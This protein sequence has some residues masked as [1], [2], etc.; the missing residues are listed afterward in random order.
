MTCLIEVHDA[1]ELDRALALDP[2]LLGIN[3]RNL[4]TLHVDPQTVIDLLPRVPAGVLAVAESGV[5]GPRDVAEYVRAGAGAVLVGEALVTGGDPAAAIR[6]F[7][8]AAAEI[9]A[10]TIGAARV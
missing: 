10:T 6:A 5:T 1:A 8:S 2:V 9:T 3:A 7:T 4:R